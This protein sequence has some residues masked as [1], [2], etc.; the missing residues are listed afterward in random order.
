MT[1]Q[2]L[3]APLV[4]AD[5]DLRNYP[6]TPIFRARLFGSAF[7]ARSNDGE[8]RAGVTLWL[9]SWDQVPAGSL[10]DD[11]VD[12]CRLAELGRDLRSWK[13]VRAGALH[14]WIRCSDGRLY[15]RVVAEGVNEAWQGK[16]SQRD[17]TE[18]ARQA[19]LSQKQSQPKRDDHDRP[20]TKSVT[21]TV[22]AS[23]RKG[24]GDR[25]GEGLPPKPPA[26]DFSVSP[27]AKAIIA[28]FDEERVK[29]FGS[30]RKRAWPDAS[31]GVI[32][33]RWADAGANAD[34]CRGVFAAILQRRNGK[35]R[36]PPN[37]LSYFENPIAEALAARSAPMPVVNG[38]GHAPADTPPHRVLLWR[39]RLATWLQSGTWERDWNIHD[40]P[41]SV[42][43]EYRDRLRAK[44]PPG[45]RVARETPDGEA[46]E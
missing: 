24:K 27:E 5:V 37:S 19:R 46:A 30:E 14:G 10:P 22:T 15:H 39:G 38:N 16:Q 33:Q 18:K 25:E 28:A 34:F 41:T 4:P 20:V 29:A 12:L 1:E 6:F 44:P 3:P 13:K 9:K 21:D 35:G 45:T 17:R 43:N 42:V 11:D 40:C 26:D 23:N 7:H 36:E 31:D 2:N 32:A 8:W